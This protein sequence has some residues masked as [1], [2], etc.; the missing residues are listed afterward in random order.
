MFSDISSPG[1]LLERNQEVLINIWLF[2]GVHHY[3]NCYKTGIPI[4]DYM[5]A[6]SVLIMCGDVPVVE[7]CTPSQ[8]NPC[9][10]PDPAADTYV[11]LD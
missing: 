9:P 1:F 3:I 2:K 6:R 5:T 7:E 4:E 10:T 11:Y 8:G